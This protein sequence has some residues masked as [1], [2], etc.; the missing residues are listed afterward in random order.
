MVCCIGLCYIYQNLEHYILAAIRFK[1]PSTL[2]LV[3]KTKI[4]FIKPL[5]NVLASLVPFWSNSFETN[6]IHH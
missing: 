4:V 6:F 1:V 2:S 5:I 3:K